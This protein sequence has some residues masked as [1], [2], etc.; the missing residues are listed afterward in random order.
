M[1]TRREIRTRIPI[2]W[3]KLSLR[4][5][6]LLNPDREGGLRQMEKGAGFAKR[7]SPRRSESTL[8]L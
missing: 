2:R 8:E 1:E 5:H 7:P 4:A 6:A 3:K